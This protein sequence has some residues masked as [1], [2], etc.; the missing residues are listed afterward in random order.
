LAEQ[1]QSKLQ[2]DTENSA[3]RLRPVNLNL[4]LNNALLLAAAAVGF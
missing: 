4:L 3:A 1:D 2:I